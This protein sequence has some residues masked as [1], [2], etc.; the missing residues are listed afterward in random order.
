MEP[1]ASAGVGTVSWVG[2]EAGTV[3]YGEGVGVAAI[4]RGRG[5]W[6][7]LGGPLCAVAIR[8]SG[9]PLVMVRL[10]LRLKNRPVSAQPPLRSS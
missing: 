10:A 1:W 2:V 5:V 6:I 8:V 9:V 4:G 7:G 3:P